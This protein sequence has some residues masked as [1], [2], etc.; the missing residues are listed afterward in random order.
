MCYKLLFGVSG[1]RISGVT[2]YRSS[3]ALPLRNFVQSERLL[4]STKRVNQTSLFSNWVLMG[5]FK[6]SNNSNIIKSIYAGD[7][8]VTMSC[9]LYGEYYTI[10]NSLII[11][12]LALKQDLFELTNHSNV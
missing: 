7:L 9:I 4:I 12:Q 8:Q 2:G 11:T 3:L 1:L 10:F 6:S 5:N